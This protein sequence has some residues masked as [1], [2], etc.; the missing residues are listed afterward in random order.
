MRESK[1]RD[2]KREC[3][4][5]GNVNSFSNKRNMILHTNLNPHEEMIKMREI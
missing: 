5:K 1:R 4:T 3:C 2:G